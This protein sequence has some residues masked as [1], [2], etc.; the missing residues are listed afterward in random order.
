MLFNPLTNIE[1]FGRYQIG[2]KIASKFQD[3]ND[4]V[5][6]VGDACHTQ[7]PNAS[8]GMNHSMH[9]SWNLAWKLNLAVRG[10]AKPS[11]LKTYEAERRQVAEDLI[12]FDYEHSSAFSSGDPKALAENFQRS[13]RFTSGFGSDYAPSVLNVPQK[14]SMLGSLR[15]GSLPPP[16]KV[17][18]YFD[19]NPV[20]IQLDI[21]MLGMCHPG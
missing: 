6:I 12:D 11:L 9:D 13:A 2:Q 17:T 21:P 15:A 8:Q 1:W 16:A 20:D 19:S 14:G 10:L 5:F 7:S 18:R 4:K 3:E